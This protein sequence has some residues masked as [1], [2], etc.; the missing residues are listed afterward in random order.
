ME[1]YLYFMAVVFFFIKAMVHMSIDYPGKVLSRFILFG[2][3]LDSKYLFPIKKKGKPDNGITKIEI[4]NW[5]IYI[6]YFLFLTTILISL[7]SRMSL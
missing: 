7:F 1:M 5:A 3:W 6:F 2:G 4:A